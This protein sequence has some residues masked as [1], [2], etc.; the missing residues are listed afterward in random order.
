MGSNQ[1]IALD[2]LLEVDKLV[3]D[4][5]A[6]VSYRVPEIVELIQAGSLSAE[7][8]HAEWPDIIAGRAVG[9]QSQ[10]EIILYIALGIWGEYA[11]ILPSVYRRAK[12][13]GF[14][15]RLGR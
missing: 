9:R 2:L 4:R 6:Y 15:M 8:V 12:E 13:L 14:G 10:D 1:E 5:W 7:D 3:V 11:A